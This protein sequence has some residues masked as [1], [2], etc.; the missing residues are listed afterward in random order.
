MPYAV[1][2]F[3][4]SETCRSCAY[5]ALLLCMLLAACSDDKTTPTQEHYL[6]CAGVRPGGWIGVY[7]CD[8]DSLIDSLGYPGMLTP[9]ELTGS[10]TG[11]YITSLESGRPTRVWDLRSRTQVSTLLAPEHAVFLEDH[12]VLLTTTLDTLRTYQLPEFAFDTAF[13]IRLRNPIRLSTQDTILCIVARGS[14][15]S[16]PDYSQIGVFDLNSLTLVDSFTVDEGSEP[17]QCRWIEPSRDGD[18]LYLLGADWSSPSVFAYSLKDRRVI[19]RANLYSALGRC[20]LSPDERELWITDPGPPPTFGEAWPGHVLVLDAKTGAILDT[21]PTFGLDEE[22]PEIRW[23]VDD[24]RFVPGGHKAYVNCMFRG[25]IL[26][27]DTR[28]KEITNFL[29]KAPKRS[30]DGIVVLPRY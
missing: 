4:S 22:F 13:W 5:W 2:R 11:L 8:N 1:A 23:R 29:L 28:S 15:G 7:D 14:A 10:S 3:L 30:A 16:P 24:I 18:V 6:L 17:V 25:P 26:V 21:I 12:G 27:I 9:S 19:F 20:R